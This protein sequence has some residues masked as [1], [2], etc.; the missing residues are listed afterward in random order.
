[1]AIDAQCS[2]SRARRLRNTATKRRLWDSAKVISDGKPESQCVVSA[3][4]FAQ[5]EVMLSQLHWHLIGPW[6]AHTSCAQ[7]RSAFP[8]EPAQNSD[9]NFNP[10]ADSFHPA[11]SEPAPP[12]KLWQ[13]SHCCGCWEPL[14]QSCLCG[15]TLVCNICAYAM[16]RAKKNNTTQRPGPGEETLSA[17]RMCEMIDLVVSKIRETTNWK[18]I[19][20]EAGE[21]IIVELK[22]TYRSNPRT[23]HTQSEAVALMEL[24]GRKLGE[25]VEPPTRHSEEARC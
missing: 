16:R 13:P 9:F 17:R 4:R 14:P 11:V 8:F 20:P 5:L 2:P 1:M 22:A 25:A 23:M 24:T 7:P 3:E 15:A 18:F 6:E 19:P 12:Y 10:N 21:R